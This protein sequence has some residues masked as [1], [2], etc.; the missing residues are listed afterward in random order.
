MQQIYRKNSMS[1]YDFNKVAKHICCL[2][3]ENLWKAASANETQN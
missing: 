1:K 2:F 3:S